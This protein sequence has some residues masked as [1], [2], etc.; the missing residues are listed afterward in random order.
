MEKFFEGLLL[1][2]GVMVIIAVLAILGGTII[3]WVWPVAIPA[4]FPGLIE[5][6]T[7]AAKLAWWPAVCFTWIC[8]ILI[9]SSQT[10]HN[11]K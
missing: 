6:G 4:V 11:S 3:Y 1:S 10:N 5:S 2:L 9:K 8:G 7:L